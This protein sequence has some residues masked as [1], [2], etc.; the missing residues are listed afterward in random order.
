MIYLLHG[1]DYESSYRRLNQIAAKYAGHKIIHLDKS[2]PREVLSQTLHESSFFPQ[3]EIIILEDLIS[4]Q[5]RIP[6]EKDIII[7]EKRAVLS[8]EIKKLPKSTIVELHNLKTTLFEFLDSLV[9]GSK[10]THK[11]AKK[12]NEKNLLWHLQ[13]RLFLLLLV[14][15]GFGANEASN[16]LHM[17]LVS[18]QWRKLQDQALRFSLSNLLDFYGGALKVDFLIKT[19]KTSLAP[20]TLTSVLLLKYL[21]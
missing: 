21:K 7:W 14:K 17:N 9:P 11:L 12:Q 13:N 16:L 1:N 8:N 3:K 5:V 19:G 18:W 10:K 15:T 4:T 2:T 6:E 20:T